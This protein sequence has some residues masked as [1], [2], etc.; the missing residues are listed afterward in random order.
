M[1]TAA[2]SRLT[3]NEHL[4][5]EFATTWP[6]YDL[7]EATRA[8]LSYAGK[9]TETPGIID[10][11]EVAKLREAGWDEPAIWEITALIAFFNFSGRLEAASGLPPDEIPEGSHFAEAAAD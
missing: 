6:N 2:V 8:L 10:E 9:L 1:H 3:G 5:F 7:D 4:D 11:A